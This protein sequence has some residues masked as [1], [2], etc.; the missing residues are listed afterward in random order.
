MPLRTGWKVVLVVAGLI[1]APR[2][3]A[4]IFRRR[5]QKRRISVNQSQ[6]QVIL[7]SQA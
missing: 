1:I 4:G 3:L 2:I 7:A 5:E 6:R